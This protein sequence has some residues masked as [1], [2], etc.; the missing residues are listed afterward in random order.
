MSMDVS[1]E[2]RPTV[3]RR[4]AQAYAELGEVETRRWSLLEPLIAS[5]TLVTV[6]SLSTRYTWEPVRNTLVFQEM[7]ARHR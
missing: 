4:W 3:Q 2:A 7:L 1:D 5:S 6:N